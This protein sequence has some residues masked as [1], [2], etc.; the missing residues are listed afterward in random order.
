MFACLGLG[1]TFQQNNHEI[2]FVLQGLPKTSYYKLID[3]WLLFSLNMLVLT[4]AL[5]TYVAHCC[6]RAKNEKPVYFN[7]KRVYPRSESKD[8]QTKKLPDL[9]GDEDILKHPK[10]VNRLGKLALLC[11]VL[12]FNSIFWTVALNEYLLSAEYYLSRDT[13]TPNNQTVDV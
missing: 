1:F 7:F 10:Q 3:W 9:D 4:M 2:N 6:F 8:D 11:V 13:S 12:L 5:H